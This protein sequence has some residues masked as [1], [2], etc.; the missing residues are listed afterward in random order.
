[1]Y[2]EAMNQYIATRL[3]RPLDQMSVRNIS[4]RGSLANHELKKIESRV[5][6]IANFTKLTWGVS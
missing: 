5:V 6:K 1:M 4:N 2:K 3:G